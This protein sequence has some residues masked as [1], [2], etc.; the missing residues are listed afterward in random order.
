[1]YPG[2]KV[3]SGMLPERTKLTMVDSKSTGLHIRAFANWTY[4]TRSL[5]PG[6]KSSTLLHQVSKSSC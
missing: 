6:S 4:R 3:V 1:M 5:N 2:R